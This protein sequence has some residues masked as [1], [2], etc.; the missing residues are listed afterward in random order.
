M[1]SD[2]HARGVLR[3]P[4]GNDAAKKLITGILASGTVN[5]T[6]HAERELAAD[7]LTPTDALKLL[8][9]GW[10][11][12]SEFENGSWRYRV[13]GREAIVVVAFRSATTLVI[14]T[15]WRLT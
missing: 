11:E 14:V 9:S 10:V 15:A 2:G 13:R 5:F 8:R 12:F 3:E 4:L 6:R 1:S 7:G